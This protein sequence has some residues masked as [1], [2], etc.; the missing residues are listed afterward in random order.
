MIRNHR[1]SGRLIL[2]RQ[3]GRSMEECERR[4]AK[5]AK[6]APTYQFRGQKPEYHPARFPEE[7]LHMPIASGNIQMDCCPHTKTK[8]NDACRQDAKGATLDRFWLPRRWTVGRLVAEDSVHFQGRGGVVVVDVVT[9]QCAVQTQRSS[10]QSCWTRR[11]QARRT[12]RP[13]S[14]VASPSAV[15]L[16]PICVS[17]VSSGLFGQRELPHLGGTS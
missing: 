4:G 8:G 2:S 6:S 17:E 16:G 10:A 1:W 9:W 12:C 14:G 3:L 11:R 15:A 7:L 13:I 5:C